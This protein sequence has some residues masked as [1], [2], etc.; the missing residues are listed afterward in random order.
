MS[1]ATYLYAKQIQ[2]ISIIYIHQTE[3][4]ANKITRF[5][6]SNPLNIYVNITS[7]SATQK[8]CIERPLLLGW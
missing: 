5:D 2:S 3:S 1:S 4:R 7:S 6:T 8:G